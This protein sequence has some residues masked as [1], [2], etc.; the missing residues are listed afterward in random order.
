MINVKKNTLTFKLY[1]FIVIFKS[2][3]FSDGRCP[4]LSFTFNF[5]ENLLFFSSP[6]DQEPYPII[7]QF[8]LLLQYRFKN[9]A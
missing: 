9:G 6:W 2:P 4:T 3:C 5:L 7:L 8:F 1:Y